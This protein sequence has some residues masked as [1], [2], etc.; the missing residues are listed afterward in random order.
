MSIFTMEPSEYTPFISFDHDLG[1][2]KI[3]GKSI[4]DN[5][6][7][8]FQPLMEN[9][10]NYCETPSSD[11]TIVEIKL[12]YSNSSSFKWIFYILEK[13]ENLYVSKKHPVTVKFYYNDESMLEMG[14]NL[15]RNLALNF[16]FLKY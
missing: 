6:V 11:K 3:E 4:P 2:L 12:E 13:F 15:Q 5:P 1:V 8:L 9:V 14:M 10:I 7:K 16:T